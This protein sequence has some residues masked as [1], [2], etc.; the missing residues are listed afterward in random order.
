MWNRRGRGRTS[1]RGGREGR[2]RALDLPDRDVGAVTA[3][4]GDRDPEAGLRVQGGYRVAVG[5]AFLGPVTVRGAGGADAGDAVRR[6]GA[7]A[8]AAVPRQRPFRI[9]GCRQSVPAR[10]RAP[11]R[12]AR[13]GLPA[14]APFFRRWLHG[15]WGSIDANAACSVRGKRRASASASRPV[16]AA[17]G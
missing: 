13:V 4:A 15:A 2:E 11:Q 12:G 10:V 17:V 6:A 14:G 1:R 5:A 7:G 9:A 16:H 3:A 8:V